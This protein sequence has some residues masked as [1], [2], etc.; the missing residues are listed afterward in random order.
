MDLPSSCTPNN[1]TNLICLNLYFTIKQVD[2]V[3]SQKK[4]ENFLIN[5]TERHKL[6]I[7]SDSLWKG[8]EENKRW[9]LL[10]KYLKR[11]RLNSFSWTQT[12]VLT[13][14][15]TQ[16]RLWKDYEIVNQTLDDIA[17]FADSRK[18]TNP[19]YFIRLNIFV[20]EKTYNHSSRKL[21]WFSNHSLF[22]I[23]RSPSSFTVQT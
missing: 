4:A 20:K 18:N 13:L 5:Y 10:N 8:Y 17:N 9:I 19:S 21:R 11:Q 1:L 7:R 23:N 12:D 16:E 3:Y 2:E 15:Q 14:V 6:F 22:S